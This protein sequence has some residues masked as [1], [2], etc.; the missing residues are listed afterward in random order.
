MDRQTGRVNC[1][2]ILCYLLFFS[3]KYFRRRNS[4]GHVVNVERVHSRSAVRPEL[5]NESVERTGVTIKS[6]QHSHLS[7]GWKVFIQTQRIGSP[8]QQY[9]DTVRT[10]DKEYSAIKER[11]Q[12]K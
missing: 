11:L 6:L 9:R 4:P 7:T 1:H 5:K 3:I 12:V 8:L 2:S 10:K